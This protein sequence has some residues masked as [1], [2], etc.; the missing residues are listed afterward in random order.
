MKL[1]HF[2]NILRLKLKCALL[3]ELQG[4]KCSSIHNKKQ[5]LGRNTNFHAAYISTQFGQRGTRT[6]CA[7]LDKILA[8]FHYKLYKRME[9]EFHL[10]TS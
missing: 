4:T 7:Q 8:H 3:R 6:K 5:F 2:L 9:L 10:L 1:K